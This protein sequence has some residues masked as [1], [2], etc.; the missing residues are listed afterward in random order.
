MPQGEDE[1]E[2]LNATRSGRAHHKIFNISTEI[3]EIQK[4][5]E[6]SEVTKAKALEIFKIIIHQNFGAMFIQTARLRM[7]PEMEAQ[8]F[9]SNIQT[10]HLH[11]TLLL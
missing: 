8:E 11:H 5:E 4:Q 2:P 10:Q 1:T 7:Q 9:T 3:S 6:S